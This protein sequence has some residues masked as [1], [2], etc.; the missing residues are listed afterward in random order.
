M[1]LAECVE[2]MPDAGEYRLREA[3]EGDGA[4]HQYRG[5]CLCTV[6]VVEHTCRRRPDSVA[7]RPVTN[8]EHA[9]DSLEF[10]SLMH[11]S[12]SCATINRSVWGATHIPFF[13]PKVLTS[14]FRVNWKIRSV[15]ST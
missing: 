5:F 1:F 3:P 6:L 8:A 7:A 2:V 12:I 13:W 14:S 11:R 4:E 9:R 10:I 15:T